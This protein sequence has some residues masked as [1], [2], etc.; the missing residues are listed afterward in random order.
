M[1]RT[2]PAYTVKWSSQI[3]RSNTRLGPPTPA[4]KAVSSAQVKHSNNIF[5]IQ[6]YLKILA[7]VAVIFL[8]H[9]ISTIV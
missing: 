2:A 3:S 6:N 5:Y 7:N 8:S 9:K 4:P 1:T